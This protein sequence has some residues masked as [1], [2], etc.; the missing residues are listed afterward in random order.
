M[1]NKI[2]VLSRVP[3]FLFYSRNDSRIRVIVL[4][5]VSLATWCRGNDRVE[6]SRQDILILILHCEVAINSLKNE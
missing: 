2:Y 3:A 5:D 6:L 1:L 4:F